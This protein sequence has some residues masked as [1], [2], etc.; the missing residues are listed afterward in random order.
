MGLLKVLLESCTLEVLKVQDFNSMLEP[1][2][3]INVEHL[4][5]NVKH[6]LHLRVGSVISLKSIV[7]ILN[8]LNFTLRYLKINQNLLFLNLNIF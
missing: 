4:S 8:R 7:V 3:S 6:F 2:D 1:L 5:D